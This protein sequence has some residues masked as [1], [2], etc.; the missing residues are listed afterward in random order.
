[1]EKAY[2]LLFNTEESDDLYV[3]CCGLSQTLPGHRFGPAM[4]EILLAEGDSRG[5]L[6]MALRSY[7][8]DAMSALALGKAMNAAGRHEEALVYLT[9]CRRRMVESGSLFR[10]DEE[11][12]A[13]AEADEALGRR[14][15]ASALRKA[16]EAARRLGFKGR[17][18]P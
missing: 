3:Y 17:C 5:A 12:E 4:S 1:M 10:M 14:E 8:G 2:K 13:E 9:A 6:D 7:T 15:R 11:M 16:A 18:C